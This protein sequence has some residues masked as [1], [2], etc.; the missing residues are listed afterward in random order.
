MPRS[1]KE[2]KQ[3][4]LEVTTEENRLA[5]RKHKQ[6]TGSAYG[7]IGFNHYKT[8]SFD[9]ALNE[10]ETFLR[11]VPMLVG[12]SLKKWERITDIQILKRSGEHHVDKMRCIQLLDAEMNKCQK[13]LGKLVFTR[14]EETKT[15]QPEQHGS[16]K[17]HKVINACLN[18]Q[19]LAPSACSSPWCLALRGAL[20]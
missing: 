18:K 6:K 1:I 9:P 2:L 13:L 10:I 16:Q 5:W 4:G 11:N 17:N 12:F 14:A 20:K 8:A 3:I 7:T 19:L 15:V